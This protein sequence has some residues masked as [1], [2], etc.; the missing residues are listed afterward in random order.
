MNLGPIGYAVGVDL[1]GTKTAAGLVA[2]DGS[3][4][5]RREVPT[6]AAAGPEAVLAT[7]IGLAAEVIAAAPEALAGDAPLVGVGIGAAG[8]VDPRTRTVLSATDTLPGWAGTRI[9]AEA[10]TALGLP[11]AVD[12]DVRAHALGE[13]RFGAGRARS[14]VLLVAA[15]TGVGGALIVGG[16]PLVGASSAAGHFGHLPAVEAQG[17]HCTCGRQG[18]VETIAAGPAIHAAYLRR[19]GTAPVPDARAVFALAEAGDPLA[20]SVVA[21]AGRAL[22]RAIG[23]L[24]NALDPDVVVVGGGLSQTSELWWG[25][26]RDGVAAE[27]I[28]LVRDRPVVPAA[29]G[30]VAALAGAGALA[31]DAAVAAAPPSSDPL[32]SSPTGARA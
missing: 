21:T 14:S 32:H 12:N 26:L 24:L 29:L 8:V 16:V 5:L 6:P 7:V 3:V 4:L 18:H 20:L 11:V 28:D 30:T 9:G 31:F 25:P 27:A 15:G 23:G 17:L 1:G 10:E 19:G 13:A 22:G 2:A